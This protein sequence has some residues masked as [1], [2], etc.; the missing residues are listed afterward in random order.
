MRRCWV[1]CL[2]ALM[3]S[4]SFAA[5]A[6]AAT[7]RVVI[8]KADG[9]PFDLLDCLVRK[10][11]P[12]TGKSVLPWIEHVFYDQGI[13]LSNFFVRGLSLS[14]PSWA[15]LDTGQRS[16]IKGN[17]EFDRFNLNER[18]D[19]LDIFSFVFKNSTKRTTDSD[20]AKLLDEYEVPL[21][22]DAYLPS[23]RYSSV[24]VISRG[25]RT[26]SLSGTLKRLL[27]LQSPKEWLDE[28][29]MGLESEKIFFELFERELISKLRNPEVQYLDLLIP[30]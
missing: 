10:K 14:G 16:P 1:T 15:V 7:D 28:W 29:V 25:L 2:L 30:F 27:T 3:L 19:Y 12:S 18:Y 5:N 26:L 6:A 11:D 20:A 22:A 21:L 24:Q 13:R 23:E 4:A 8:I 17:L 9:L